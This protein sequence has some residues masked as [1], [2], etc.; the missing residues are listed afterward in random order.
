MKRSLET[1]RLKLSLPVLVR[2]ALGEQKSAFRLRDGATD[3]AGGF[4]PL[5]DDGFRVLQSLYASAAVRGAP[6]QFRDFGDEGLVVSAP[7]E[8]DLAS[9]GPCCQST[10]S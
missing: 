1:A 10:T 3:F 7:V 5:L 8:D 4:N 9:F 2:R 6:R